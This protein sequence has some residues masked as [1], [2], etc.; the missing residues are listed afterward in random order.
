MHLGGGIQEANTMF[1]NS[2][3]K[4]IQAGQ[5]PTCALVKTGSNWLRGA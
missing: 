2:W 5:P 1:I 3:L 4:E